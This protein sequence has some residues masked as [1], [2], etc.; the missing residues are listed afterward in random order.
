ME[1]HREYSRPSD[2]SAPGSE[3]KERIYR[4][5]SVKLYFNVF[6]KSIETRGKTE[7]QWHRGIGT[8]SETDR[9]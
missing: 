2:A 1:Y 9:R 8:T 3:S 7:F 6:G 5:S 4:D